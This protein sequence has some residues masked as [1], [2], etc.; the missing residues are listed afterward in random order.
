MS[1]QSILEQIEEYINGT[2]NEDQIESLWATLIDR[3]DYREYL[4]TLNN[5]RKSRE[6]GNE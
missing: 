2:L 4:V 5:L 6:S 1:N 3:P